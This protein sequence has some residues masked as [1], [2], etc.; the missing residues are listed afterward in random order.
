M[1]GPIQPQAMGV[2]HIRNIIETG[3]TS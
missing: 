3:T 1:I 2:T